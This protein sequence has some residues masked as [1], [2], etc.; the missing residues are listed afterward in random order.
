MNR[1]DN[2][3]RLIIMA[4]LFFSITAPAH[5]YIDPGTAS[6]IYTVGLAPVLVFLA[7]LGRRIIRLIIHSKDKQTAEE[8]TDTESEA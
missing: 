4:G 7:W 6:V 5:A 1:F 3:G 2:W 8:E